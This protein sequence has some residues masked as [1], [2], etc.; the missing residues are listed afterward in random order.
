MDARKS[1]VCRCNVGFSKISPDKHVDV[2]VDSDE[3]RGSIPLA[4]KLL[5]LSSLRRDNCESGN[6]SDNTSANVGETSTGSRCG[7]SLEIRHP[8]RFVGLILNPQRVRAEYPSCYA[9]DEKKVSTEH[10]PP[11]C[12]FPETKDENGRSLY[13]K[14]LITVPS[15]EVHNTSKSDDDLYAAF[16]L[17]STT[18]GNHCAQL[19]RDGVIARRIERDQTERG[20]AL[21]RRIL[22]QIRGFIGKNPF[23]ELDAARMV[24]FLTLCAPGLYFY[25][26]FKPLKLPLRVAS[27]DYDLANNPKK[28]EALRLQRASFD[29]EMRGSEYRGSNPDVF[30]YA[31]CEKPERDVTMIEMIFLGELHRW[32]F[33]HPNAERQVF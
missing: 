10:A 19:V 4:S 9:C 12:F 2:C 28:S 16:H 32:A 6:E 8:I 17:A 22:T 21:T 13:R 18:R 30:Q 15:C 11:L 14:N 26:K 5:I 1:A 27:L 7:G 23:G 25:D 31:I 20:G 33:Y 24:R 29:E 3:D